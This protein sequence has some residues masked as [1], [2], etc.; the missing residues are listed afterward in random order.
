MSASIVV[1][2]PTWVQKYKFIHPDGKHYFFVAMGKFAYGDIRRIGCKHTDTSKMIQ[3]LKEVDEVR[4]RYFACWENKPE[5][6][7]VFYAKSEDDAREIMDYLWTNEKVSTVP[8]GVYND[9]V[10]ELPQEN[11]N[12]TIHKTI[13]DLLI[14]SSTPDSQLVETLSSSKLLSVNRYA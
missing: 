13:A 2:H 11:P 7:A 3:T 4:K 8:K 12:H 1:P 10:I 5:N 6:C 9:L 14:L